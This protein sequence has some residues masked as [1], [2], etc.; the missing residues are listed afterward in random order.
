ML[1][2]SIKFWII[3]S[4]FVLVGMSVVIMEGYIISRSNPDRFDINKRDI[5]PFIVLVIMGPITPVIFLYVLY[6]DKKE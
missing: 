2:L 4:I 3:S 1:E 6:N 5:I